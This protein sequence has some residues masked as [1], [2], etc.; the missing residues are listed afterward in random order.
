MIYWLSNYEIADW[1][2]YFV[3]DEGEDNIIFCL[4]RPYSAII[5]N[6][7]FHTFKIAAL[8]A[9]QP[10]TS[11]RTTGVNGS[12]VGIRNVFTWVV[13]RLLQINTSTMGYYFDRSYQL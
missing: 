6:I 10:V 13:L 8:N 5:I 2:M 1:V 12:A 3:F 4:L 7:T 11:F 9:A